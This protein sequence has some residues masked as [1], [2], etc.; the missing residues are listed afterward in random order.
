MP[1]YVLVYPMANFP[2]K[3][4]FGPFL[5]EKSPYLEGFPFSPPIILVSS[6]MVR[7]SL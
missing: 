1:K 7:F 4:V 6:A 3:P 5:K 2:V